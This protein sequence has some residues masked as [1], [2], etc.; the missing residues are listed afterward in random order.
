MGNKGAPRNRRSA[1]KTVLPLPDEAKSVGLQSPLADVASAD[2]VRS[3][4]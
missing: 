1:P 4:R 2:V 3:F